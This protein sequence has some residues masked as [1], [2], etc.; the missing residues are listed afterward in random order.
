MKMAGITVDVCCKPT[1][2]TA[3]RCL[4]L[5][6]WFMNDNAGLQIVAERKEYKDG[7][8]THYRI[9][10]AGTDEGQSEWKDAMMNTFLAG[11]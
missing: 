3:E 9:A 6:E 7:V 10:S 11:K 1:M 2:E 4:K 8:Y 5:L